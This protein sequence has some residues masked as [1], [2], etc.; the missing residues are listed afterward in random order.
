ML[1]VTL[2]KFTSPNTYMSLPPFIVDFGDNKHSEVVV[3]V[4]GFL[5]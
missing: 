1:N 2:K 4:T 3:E 5:K